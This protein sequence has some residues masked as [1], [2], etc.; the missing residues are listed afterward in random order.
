MREFP[1]RE[2]ESRCDASASS[3]ARNAS[4]PHRAPCSA[5]RRRRRRVAPAAACGERER[6]KVS[7]SRVKAPPHKLFEGRP[8]VSNTG[9]HSTYIHNVSAT[10]PAALSKS[11][12]H[13]FFSL[14]YSLSLCFEHTLVMRIFHTF[15]CWKNSK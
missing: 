5:R 6:P 13:M 8:C 4:H 2:R 3:H 11:H 10:A 7:Y 9:T 15:V 12:P 1:A 14:L